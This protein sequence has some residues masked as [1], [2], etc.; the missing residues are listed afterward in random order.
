[1][2]LKHI[3][4]ISVFALFFANGYAQDSLLFLIKYQP[5]TTYETTEKTI[6]DG[7]MVFKGDKD[8]IDLLKATGLQN[9]TAISNEEHSFQTVTTGPLKKDSSYSLVVE[10][11]KVAALKKVNGK[12]STEV[13]PES[14]AKI[15]GLYTKE[16]KF[17]I[18]EVDFKTEQTEEF[19]KQFTKA[20]KSVQEQ[21][22][23]EARMVKVGE[24]F[25]VK[26][27]MNIPITKASK[28]DMYIVIT[29]KLKKIKDGIGYFTFK[30]HLEMDFNVKE[31]KLYASGK[32]KGKATYD[33]AEDQF[34][35]Y[36]SAIKMKMVSALNDAVKMHAKMTV[37]NE[38][39]VKVKN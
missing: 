18:E 10:Y 5:S 36:E 26:Q 12:T 19:K 11:G 39:Q 29:Y 6:T 1:M 14:G 28:M 9:P 15:T 25:E 21:L 24:G 34:L 16:G 38:K 27:P 13:S 2:K 4:F 31:L 17:N 22:S 8:M 37:I 7:K 33:I 32:G 20:F 30:Q 23:V 35:D 3:F